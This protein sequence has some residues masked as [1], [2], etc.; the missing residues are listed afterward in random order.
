M[1]TIRAQILDVYVHKALS[2]WYLANAET[3]AYQKIT[4]VGIGDFIPLRM[5]VTMEGTWETHR[6]HG[7]Q[8]KCKR[9]AYGSHLESIAGLLS[10]G[11]LWGIRGAKAAEMVKTLGEDIVQVLDDAARHAAAELD[12]QTSEG[13]HAHARMLAIKGIGPYVL[14]E[15]LASWREERDWALAALTC[16]RCGLSLKQAKRVFKLFV[17]ETV[18]VIYDRPYQL[19]VIPGITWEVADAIAKE[20]WEGKKP[21]DHNAPIRFAAAVREILR[22]QRLNGQ[23]CVYY[24]EVL[25]EAIRLS[26]PTLNRTP[27]AFWAEID[28]NLDLID[29]AI[30]VVEDEQGMY[31]YSPYM[32]RV[33]EGA[34]GILKK[35]VAGQH[36]VSSRWPGIWKEIDH[37]AYAY[38]P[39]DA[40]MS[41]DQKK[42]LRLYMDEP[43]SIITGGPGTGKST[44]LGTLCRI[45]RQMGVTY[46]LCTP[47][48]KAARRMTETIRS[49]ASTIHRT[50]RLG[51][52][53]DDM[54]QDRFDTDYVII[55]E[56]S[57]CDAALF[58]KVLTAVPAGTK[59][60]LVGDADQLP[61][62]GPG[63][64]F[65]Q[66]IEG[67]GLPTARL[68]V[69]HRQDAGSGI[70]HAAAS[71]REGNMPSPDGYHDIWIG[72]CGNNADMAR[73]TT[74]LM[75]K[76]AEKYGC[77]MSDIQVLTPLNGHAWGQMELNRKLQDLI[78]PGPFPLNGCWFKPGDR[79]IQLKNNYQLGEHGIMNGQ[80]GTVDWIASD[81]DLQFKDDPTVAIVI[82]DN[83][84][85]HYNELE[86]SDLGLA[87]ALTI[88]KVQGSEYDRVIMLVPTTRPS[89]QTRQLVYTGLTRAKQ[90]ILILTS[91]DAI[92]QY[93]SNSE[94]IRR[95]TLLGGW[96]A[97]TTHEAEEMDLYHLLE[98]EAGDGLPLEELPAEPGADVLLLQEEY[99]Y[100]P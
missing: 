93:I 58:Y 76:V 94:R 52:G 51:I 22:L 2:G 80:I 40:R 3:E 89:F 75:P 18:N 64:P 43:V 20:K 33:E 15:L 61:P 79:V 99:L 1:D 23:A 57:M 12:E 31:L 46:T 5:V 29:E 36:R 10:S 8:F 53:E 47:T 24:K 4:V 26:K 83:E 49:P 25:D 41:D 97:G 82:Y 98:S 13:R 62:V 16:T 9:I 42:A 100:Y 19:T 88:H 60:V 44:I 69:I 35:L 78:N 59:L 73:Q 92:W 86:M 17:K 50:L 7:R 39:T 6:K 37:Y 90:Y 85:V 81:E 11:F 38:L 21:I 70:I 30:S 27:F 32:A 72:V 65:Y 96:F 63:E 68:T 67:V 66:C 48:G 14:R 34:A 45:L 87:Y 84:Y 95:N 91:Q 71:I 28:M 55:D 54:P 56:M 74:S 77:P